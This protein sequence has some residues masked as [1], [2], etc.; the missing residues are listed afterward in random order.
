MQPK[1]SLG[2]G[3][4][5]PRGN[6]GLALPLFPSSLCFKHEEQRLRLGLLPGF[7][8]RGL[9]LPQRA[10]VCRREAELSLERLQHVRMRLAAGAGSW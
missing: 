5:V 6:E 8:Q 10:R 9:I 1:F 2:A 7:H 4:V 3:S